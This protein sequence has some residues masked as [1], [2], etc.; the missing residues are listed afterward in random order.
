MASNK[1]THRWESLEEFHRW[2]ADEELK[3]CIELCLG[4]RKPGLPAFEVKT[5]YV[6]SRQGTDGKKVYVKKHPE[7]SQKL[8]N[9]NT[10]CECAVT[11]K[12]YPGRTTMLGSYH[13]THN[14]PILKANLPF[15][16][17]LKE[18]REYIA[19]LVRLKVA[20]DHIIRYLF[21]TDI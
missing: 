16:C 3:N 7:R 6:C 8:G 20:P 18:T 21:S 10:G 15:T 11:V 14:H 12:Q 2:R 4:N 9:K 17:I 1:F 19:G 5:R 13:D